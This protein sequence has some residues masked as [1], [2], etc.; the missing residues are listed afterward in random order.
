MPAKVNRKNGRNVT[1]D[2]NIA[3]RTVPG[4]SRSEDRSEQLDRL[5]LELQHVILNVYKT[6]FPVL[7][8][9]ETLQENIQKVKGFLFN[10]DFATAFGEQKNLEAYAVRW[11]AARSLAYTSVFCNQSRDFLLDV[12]SEVIRTQA[13]QVS[14]TEREIDEAE[15]ASD[16]CDQKLPE[17]RIV[18]V[19]GGA[20]A[21]IVSLAATH[22]QFEIHAKTFITAVDIADWSMP[23]SELAAAMYEPPKLSVHASEAAKA[24][25][26][27]QPL[28]VKST[29]LV[30][31]S[32]QQ[33]DVLSWDSIAMK[34]TLKN[35]NLCTIMFTL[36]ELFT[37]SLQKTTAFLLS[38][39]SMMISG[40][41]LLIVDSPG[42]YS[43]IQLQ[44]PNTGHTVKASQGPPKRYPMKWLLDHTLLTI[45]KNGNEPV[46]N[47]LEDEDS[48][49]FRIDAKDREKLRYSVELENMRY[50]L[51][52]YRRI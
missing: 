44:N 1:K 46:W 23:V 38:L 42:S 11:S 18:C 49:W 48:L 22:R 39:T 50:Q 9:Y 32:F 4:H 17:L 14:G 28:L 5:P 21:E 33:Q 35:A 6:A 2:K 30:E 12:T 19:G 8:E 13:E 34:E 51:H 36:N 29:N 26:E 27:N 10:R 20:G 31:I 16:S 15:S 24:R 47:K 25:P 37:A 7:D 3:T 43:E 52:L 40:S 41:H 45:A